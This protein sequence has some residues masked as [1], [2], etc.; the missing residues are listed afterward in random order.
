MTSSSDGLLRSQCSS[1]SQMCSEELKSELCA[2]GLCGQRHCHAG[3]G[4]GPQSSS[5]I[6]M[7]QHTVTGKTIVWF[8]LCDNSLGKTHECGGHVM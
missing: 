7:L 1:S 3:A 5:E 2:C 8:S 4:L 6:L